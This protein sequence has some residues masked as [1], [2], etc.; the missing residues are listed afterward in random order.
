M[1]REE[2]WFKSAEAASFEH[3]DEVLSEFDKRFGSISENSPI[4]EE[5]SNW[6]SV[7]EGTNHKGFYIQASF[8]KNWECFV[9]KVDNQSLY[10]PSH[11]KATDAQ[12]WWSDNWYNFTKEATQSNES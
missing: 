6:N 2:V 8:N 4:P 3:A 1:T 11:V 12:S 5:V 9:V 10:I 7:L